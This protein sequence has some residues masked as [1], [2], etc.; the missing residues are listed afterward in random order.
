V[1]ARAAYY[2]VVPAGA[3]VTVTLDE[4]CHHDL[5]PVLITPRP[6]DA[7]IVTGMAPYPSV[8]ILS[9]ACVQVPYALVLV[10]VSAVRVA[11]FPWR[12]VGA[13]IADVI[14]RVTG[15]R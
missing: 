4:P 6:G 11:L 8:D 1:T 5:L 3:R 13:A 10:P 2:G 12:D 14:S 15:K 9:K 7:V